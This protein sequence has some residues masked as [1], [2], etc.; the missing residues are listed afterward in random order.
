MKAKEGDKDEGQGG[1]WMSKT[2]DGKAEAVRMEASG[3]MRELDLVLVAIRRVL[4][5]A[6]S[7][8]K[9]RQTKTLN[10]KT[11]QAKKESP[12]LGSWCSPW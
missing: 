2:E 1:R 3:L 11:K 7:A 6:T 9:T 4:S 5:T 8:D 10:G 12:G